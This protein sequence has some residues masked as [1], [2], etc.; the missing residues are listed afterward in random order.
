MQEPTW[1]STWLTAAGKR[2]TRA[3]SRGNLAQPA[4]AFAEVA[5]GI[6]GLA[7]HMDFEMKVRA[8][9]GTRAAGLADD[10]ADGHRLAGPHERTRQMRVH[11]LE[12]AAVAND[13]YA[14]VAG[15]V[16]Q[17]SHPRHDPG[18]GRAHDGVRVGIEVQ[19]PVH[20]APAVAEARLE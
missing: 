10:F 13:H 3:I 7:L 16:R 6:D 17:P 1:A 9:A 12:A 18:Q 20:A 8:R 5:Q 11:R 2:R 15:V 4:N 19:S 14:P